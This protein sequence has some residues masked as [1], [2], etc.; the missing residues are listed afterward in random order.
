MFSSPPLSS[1]SPLSLADRHK[2]VRARRRPGRPQ[3]ANKFSAVAGFPCPAPITRFSAARVCLQASRPQTC[4]A[5]WARRWLGCTGLGPGRCSLPGRKAGPGSPLRGGQTA[6]AGPHAPGAQGTTPLSLS[7]SPPASAPLLSLLSPS[8]P[9]PPP[10][11]SAL[12]SLPALLGVVM[13]I[14]RA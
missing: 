11:L 8:L 12:S 6:L 10:P 7:P 5:A 1:L 14:L 2:R 13:G 3:Y 9:P 4:Q